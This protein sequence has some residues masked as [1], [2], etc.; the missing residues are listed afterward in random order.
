M[1]TMKHV[2]IGDLHG[3]DVWRQ[4][5]IAKYDKVVFLGDYVD[6]FLFPDLVIDRNLQDII[7]LKKKY[8]EKVILLLG[9]HDVQYMFYPH[10]RCS[11]FR[12]SMK[13][14]LGALFNLNYDLFQVA[15]QCGNCLFTHAGLSN[16]WYLEFIRLPRWKIKDRQESLAD[17]L[18]Y[19]NGTSH[20][21]LLHCA[22][23]ARGGVGYGGITWADKSETETDCLIG[24]HQIVGHTP[25]K[26]VEQ[27]SFG[28]TSI[29]Y[30]DVLD[31]ITY[32]HEMEC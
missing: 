6:D 11:G 9:N 25:V 13:R 29:T 27:I 19:T 1:P 23:Y 14:P 24:Y 21:D 30:L 3:K 4:V 17:I 2:I 20:R 26:Y 18:N 7:T 10:F 22:G 28:D 15:Y 5:E 12:D 16:A 31:S 32:F 8:P